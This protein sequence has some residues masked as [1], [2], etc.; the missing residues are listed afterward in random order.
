MVDAREGE[1]MSRRQIRV[2]VQ[3]F[4]FLLALVPVVGVLALVLHLAGPYYD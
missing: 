3:G 4:A 2:S 1:C